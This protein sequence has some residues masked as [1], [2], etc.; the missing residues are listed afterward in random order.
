MEGEVRSGLDGLN[1]Y[2][3]DARKTS[4]LEMPFDEMEL[5]RAVFNCEKVKSP[6][7]DDFAMAIS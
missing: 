2:P 1:C 3:I 4:W 5:R 7:L 6:L